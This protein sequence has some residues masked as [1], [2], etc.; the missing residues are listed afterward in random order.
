MNFL[1]TNISFFPSCRSTSPR[2]I[3]LCAVLDN[4][5]SDRYAQLVLKARLARQQYQ[6]DRYRAL[7]ETF[8]AVTFSGTFSQRLNSCLTAHSG[9]IC[10]DF[11]TLPDLE[12]ARERLHGDPY[13]AFLFV[14]PSG[15][16]LKA[17]V[18]IPPKKDN[19]RHGES[20][21]SLE[22]YYR[23]TY[24]LETDPACKDVARL[25]FL[26][27][28][29]E[30]FVNQDAPVFTGIIAIRKPAPAPREYSFTGAPTEIEEVRRA[31]SYFPADDRETWLHIGMALHTIDRFDLW[32]EWSR[33]SAKYDERSQH[34]TWRGFGRRDGIGMGTLFHLACEHG[35]EFEPPD[36]PRPNP[37]G[38][39][40]R[41]D[42]LLSPQEARGEL[43]TL[44]KWFTATG[45]NMIIKASQGLGKTS[46]VIEHLLGAGV[47]HL[48]VPTI[49]LGE[50]LLRTIQEKRPELS[51]LVIRG[52]D[53][54]GMCRKPEAARRMG[55]MGLPVFSCLCK[56]QGSDTPVPMTC[57]F[58]YQ[59]RYLQQFERAKSADFV[60]MAHNT[61]VNMR[62]DRLNPPEAARLVIDESFFS[63]FVKVI[64]VDPEAIR[65]LL[66]D[67]PT[68]RDPDSATFGDSLVA[69][70]ERR[71]FETA[72]DAMRGGQRVHEMLKEAGITG[73]D[74]EAAVKSAGA[75]MHRPCITPEMPEH[76]VLEILSNRKYEPL[77][78]LFRCLQRDYTFGRDQ[79][80]VYD[81]AAGKI[82]LRYILAPKA[83]K[84]TPTLVIDGDAD[85]GIIERVL[86]KTF[87]FHEIHVARSSTVIQA[88]GKIF[89]KNSVGTGSRGEEQNDPPEPRTVRD[90][91]AFLTITADKNPGKRGLVVT[92][93]ALEESGALRLPNGWAA[94]HFGGIRGLDRYRDYD[95][96]VIIGRNQPTVRDVEDIA[97]AIF[98]D[99]PEPIMPVDGDR[100]PTE[101]RGYLMKD[102]SHA[103]TDVEFH[104]DPRADA[105]LRQ[106]R[107]C[108]TVQAISR[109]RD[110]WGR[111]KTVYLLSDLPVE[112]PVDEL[113]PWHILKQGGTRF[114]RM[115][116]R[117]DFE[118]EVLPLTGKYC[119][120]AFPD[121]W[122]TEA[123][124]RKDME[125]TARDSAL[126]GEQDCDKMLYIYSIAKCH[127]LRLLKIK[128]LGV[129]T[130]WSY[131]VTKYSPERTL[132]M[133]SSQFFGEYQLHPEDS[134]SPVQVKVTQPAAHPAVVRL[135]ARFIPCGMASVQPRVQRP[136]LSD[137]VREILSKIERESIPILPDLDVA[138]YAAAETACVV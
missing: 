13:T 44:V 65:D 55:N 85:R 45:K 111:G 59:C 129:K 17:G 81:A 108:E 121:L 133:L 7:K 95:V 112:I 83:Y 63:V 136:P 106:I 57:E 50:D 29:P 103:G 37:V 10:L 30:L 35:F 79:Q 128:G 135:K 86:G 72:L 78:Q 116:Q 19:D 68:V 2:H 5:R 93:K 125:R 122:G 62:N 71:I 12:D 87:T 102:G 54:E 114:E 97:A 115:L 69:E 99:D 28:D 52:R 27:W 67:P 73:A 25:C 20:Y 113:R 18:R 110:I 47:V 109:I 105:V 123:V 60:I 58:Y 88:T 92:Y 101:P 46:S 53:Q 119:A 89:S 21:L 36:R 100:F 137:R 51:G 126:D 117:F 124:F 33:T 131:V 23:E 132:A 84:I 138:L 48:L 80:A 64:T 118:E 32:D 24:S 3:T 1:D 42:R 39:S 31:L 127:N 75:R 15:S 49:K 6:T 40:Y 26:S 4:I 82:R 120:R 61:L 38:P 8:P 107:E 90:I 76:K 43:D 96:A 130:R 16:G 94:E 134:A 56:M 77:Y 66:D 14:S 70:E 9:I 34:R 98:Q 74:L 41:H 11:D 104:P 91:N 22:R